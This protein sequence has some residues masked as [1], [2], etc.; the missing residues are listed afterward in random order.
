MAD[1]INCNWEIV[2]EMPLILRPRV[3]SFI[4]K[5]REIIMANKG[6]IIKLT[7]DNHNEA[8]NRRTQICRD[9]EYKF[10]ATVRANM[11]YLDLREVD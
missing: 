8:K 3:I 1:E 6:K 2:A 11:L 5:V 10:P 9:I 4:K 7:F